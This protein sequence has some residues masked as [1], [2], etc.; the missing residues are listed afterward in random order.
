[1]LDFRSVNFN[2]GIKTRKVKILKDDPTLTTYHL[3]DN[4]I[5]ELSIGD[6]VLNDELE[7]NGEVP[8]YSANVYEEFGRINKKNIKD[9]SKS[10]ILWGI[11]GDWMVNS[12]PANKEFYPTDHCGVLRLKTDKILLDYLV[13]AL[14]VEGELER[15]SRNYRASIQKVKQ[16]VIQVPPLEKQK[17]IISE[18]K[19]CEDLIKKEESNIKSYDEKIKSKFVEMFGN[20]N[21]IKS[22]P[23]IE[24]TNYFE[25]GDWIESKDQSNTGVRLLQVG[26]IGFGKYIEKAN[27]RKYISYET[28]KKL[29]CKKV[30]PGDLLFSRLPKPVG[31]SCIIPTTVNEA[32]TAVDCTIVRFNKLINK[33]YFLELSKTNYWKSLV[34]EKSLEF[35]DIE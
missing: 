32:I 18:I 1:M 23:L 35:L 10:S 21:G 12:I 16:L 14:Q 15:F 34:N 11:D 2:K 25:D 8:V 7:E 9:F 24:T 33:Y 30:L 6:R 5:F 17:E 13:H 26:N 31:R 19:G 29:N 3:S 27:N 28:Y 20:L 4:K 22:L